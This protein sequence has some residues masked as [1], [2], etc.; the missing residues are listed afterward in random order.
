MLEKLK[1]TLDK[2]VAAVSVKSESLVE[3]SRT[4]TALNTAQK[5]IQAAIDA[6]GSKFYASWASGQMDMA[7]L[8]EECRKI[9]AMESEAASLRDRLERIKA[10]ESQILGAQ[11][12][13]AAPAAV[14]CTN[15]GKRLEPGTR[16]C[17]ECGTPVK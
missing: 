5:N 11:K 6:L 14:F 15:C 10:E 3:S 13:P 2:G 12:K 16:F 8:E 1:D 4:R 17:D 7:G 9:Q